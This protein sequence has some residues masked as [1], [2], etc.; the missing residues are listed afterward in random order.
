MVLPN[1]GKIPKFQFGKKKKTS[2][3]NDPFVSYIIVHKYIHFLV[4][5][6]PIDVK[7]SCVIW[8]R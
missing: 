3:E 2:Q 7:I 1:G 4:G 5:L 8:L 6:P